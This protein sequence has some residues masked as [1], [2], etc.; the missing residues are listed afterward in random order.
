MYASKN[1]NTET[2]NLY[3]QPYSIR[4]LYY[5]YYYFPT[6]QQGGQVKYNYNL[7]I[8]LVLCHL[9]ISPTNYAFNLSIYQACTGN[10][11]ETH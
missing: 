8:H 9:L 6:V 1:S 11:K 7:S 2:P 10:W 4:F 5:Y 3:T